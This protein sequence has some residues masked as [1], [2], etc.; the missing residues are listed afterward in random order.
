[1]AI[2]GNLGKVNLSDLDITVLLHLR[3]LGAFPFFIYHCVCQF[4]FS[5]FQTQKYMVFIINNN[6]GAFL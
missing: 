5:V 1:M 4:F 6:D 3:A 2:W